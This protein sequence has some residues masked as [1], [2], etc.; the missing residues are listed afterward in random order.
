MFY[1]ILERIE[2]ESYFFLLTLKIFL[3]DVV[4]QILQ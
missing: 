3:T 2:L 4:Y 1:L